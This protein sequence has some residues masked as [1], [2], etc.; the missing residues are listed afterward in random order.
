MLFQIIRLF[1]VLVL[2]PVIFRLIDP[3]VNKAKLKTP[4]RYFYRGEKI[5]NALLAVPVFVVGALGSL[6]L[7]SISFPAGALMGSIFSVVAFQV[8]FKKTY[9]PPQNAYL[10]ILS[11]LGGIIGINMDIS[12]FHNLPLFLLPLT[13]V[14]SATIGGAFLLAYIIL[15]LFHRE[16]L[17]TLLGVMP[18]GL[19][20]MLSL[21]ESADCDT[22]YVTTLQTVRLITAIILLPN[23]L[24]FLGA[25]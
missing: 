12:V 20:V 19:V 1:C 21:A 8:L 3:V 14:V 7:V 13:L 22:L 6:L 23:L 15:L 17:S 10:V 24:Y 16:Y 5:S 4:A 2:I 25:I 11:F 9:K 18:G